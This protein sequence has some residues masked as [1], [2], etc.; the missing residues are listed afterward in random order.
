M[1]VSHPKIVILKEC[2]LCA[3]E[4]PLHCFSACSATTHVGTAAKPTLSGVEGLFGEAK[5]AR[6]ERTLLSVAF[7]VAVD[8]DPHSIPTQTI[9]TTVEERRF[10][11]A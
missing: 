1:T 9:R 5:R 8:F 4:G 11:A 2:A 7:D 3:T 6:V 10:S